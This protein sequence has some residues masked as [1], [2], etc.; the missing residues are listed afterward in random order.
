MRV[1]PGLRPELHH[2]DEARQ[3]LDLHAQVGVVQ[4]AGQEEQLRARVDFLP[5]PV[6]DVLTPWRK[7]ALTCLFLLL[8]LLLLLDHVHVGHDGHELGHAVHLADVDELEV[9][10]FE[11][12]GGV[13]QEQR[14]VRDFGDVYHGVDVVGDF[15]QRDAP[16]LAGHQRDGP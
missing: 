12:E 3:V 16:L 2:R 14:Q 10:H 6:L 8:E 1:A 13:D 7:T 4:D 9:L 15:D 5:K 11:A